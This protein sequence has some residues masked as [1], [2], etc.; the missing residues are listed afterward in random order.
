MPADA[1]APTITG[2]EMA[3]G[4]I[5]L[6]VADTVP[7]LT[8]TIESGRRLGSFAIDGQADIRDGDSASEI[9]LETESTSPT[10]FFRVIRAE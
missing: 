1:Q 3:D 6:S 4:V 7:Y 8:Y 5:T 10:R 2:L 9:V